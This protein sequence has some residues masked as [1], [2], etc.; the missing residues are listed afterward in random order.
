[1]GTSRTVACDPTLSVD[2]YLDATNV[3]DKETWM[4]RLE[5]AEQNLSKLRAQSWLTVAERVVKCV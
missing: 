1:M 3:C 5:L 2:R 4:E